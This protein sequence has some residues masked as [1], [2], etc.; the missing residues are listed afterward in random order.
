MSAIL[1]LPIVDSPA[2]WIIYLLAVALTITLLVRDP[3]PKWFVR[4]SIGAVAGALLGMGIY[5]AGN[6]LDLFGVNLPLMVGVWTT[7]MF[8]GVGL[9]I[10][11]FPD[12]KPWRKVVASV[13]ILAY[14][15]AGATG[16]NAFYGLNP[17]LGSVFGDVEEAQ[18]SLPDSNPD[19][20][21]A[22][23]QPLS[24]TWQAPSN[25][26][27]VG[28]R[29]SAPIPGTESGFVA[30]DAGI[31][32][33]PAALVDNAPALPVIIMMMGYP[34]N[35]DGTIISDVLD[36]FAA[37]NN[38]LAP[39]V[40]IADQLGAAGVQDPACAD[41]AKYGNAETYITTDVVNWANTNL[42]VIKDPKYWTIAG[43]SNGGG[44]AAK[45]G[46]KHPDLFK[47]VIS[48]SGEEFPGSEGADAAT[49]DIY[50]GDTTAFEASKPINI[51]K[52]APAG[53]YSGMTAIFTAGSEDPTF[54]AAATAVSQAAEAVGIATTLF[55]VQGADHG[56]DAVSGGLTEGFDVLYPVLGLSTGT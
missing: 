28:E 18:I 1:E 9:A 17:T 49:A 21:A 8:A 11:S 54:A 40:I 50:G 31:Y 10:A 42:N 39:I 12:A 34:G 47:N 26:P 25:M 32:L 4:A 37:K 20:R 56:G 2:M 23:A 48:V 19:N 36:E 3:D 41:S 22:P 14:L 24:A 35:P 46:A 45:Y 5:F 30:R 27:S 44:C 16:I 52:A 33:P 55:L 7:A 6:L 29:G 38:G 15:L 51:M 13:A 43:Y 53:S